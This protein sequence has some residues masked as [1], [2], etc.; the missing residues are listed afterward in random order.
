M[1]ANPVRKP[2]LTTQMRIS[3]LT[4]AAAA[5]SASASAAIT[6][7]MQYSGASFGNTAAAY[8]TITLDETV[9]LNPTNGWAMSNLSPTVLSLSL[10]VTGAG[11]GNGVFTESDFS[12]WIWDTAG[13]TLNLATQLVGQSTPTLPWGT[14]GLIG[15]TG[16][17]GGD[18]N[19]FSVDPNSSAPTGIWYFTLSA[20]DG[21]YMRLTSFTSGAIPEPSTYGIVLGGL[22]LA[23]AIASRRRKTA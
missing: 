4:L 9:L 8:G 12:S 11:S 22:A 5:C 1:L 16:T 19:L 20:S 3:V 18:F 7:N 17:N 6:F 15:I 10:T 2:S 13:A 14:A 21:S 23:G